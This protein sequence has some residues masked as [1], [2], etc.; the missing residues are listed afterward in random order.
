MLGNI[1]FS[2]KVNPDFQASIEDHNNKSPGD[3]ATVYKNVEPLNIRRFKTILEVLE[4]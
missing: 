4:L 1:F 3:K 2:K